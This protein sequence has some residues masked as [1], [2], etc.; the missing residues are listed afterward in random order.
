MG[1]MNPSIITRDELIRDYVRHMKAGY[2]TLFAGAGLS[3]E[4]GYPA[5]ADLLQDDARKLGVNL[6]NLNGYDYYDFANWYCQ[7]NSDRTTLV[8][9]IV[10]EI[11]K[12]RPLSINHRLIAR[13][14]LSKIW[15]TN[16]DK[17]LETALLQQSRKV[18]VISRD[19]DFPFSE[20]EDVKV[21]KMH[22][23]IHF[24]DDIVIT[25][26]DIDNYLR[27][28]E[29]MSNVF[30]SSLAQ[31]CFLF[32]GFGFKDLNFKAI[33]G[34][35]TSRYNNISRRHFAVLKRPDD[36]KE[37]ITFY[38]MISDLSKKGIKAYLIDS[39]DEIP[40]LLMDIEK[41]YIRDNIFV[42]GSFDKSFPSKSFEFPVF[43]HDNCRHTS[44]LSD[45][46]RSF[47]RGVKSR[48]SKEIYP[49]RDPFNSMP[50][51]LEQLGERMMNE[52][53]TLYT[54]FGLGVCDVVVEGASRK[55]V[56]EDTYQSIVNNIKIFPLP[57]KFNIESFHNQFYR[58]N[59]IGACGFML[60]ARGATH[61]SDFTSGSFEEYNIAKGLSNL[62]IGQQKHIIQQIKAWLK[63]GQHDHAGDT[64]KFREKLASL[65]R[66]HSTLVYY[67]YQE[68]IEIFYRL[69]YEQWKLVIRSLDACKFRADQQVHQHFPEWKEDW[70]KLKTQMETLVYDRAE[71][72]YGQFASKYLQTEHKFS[73]APASQVMKGL[74][75]FTAAIEKIAGRKQKHYLVTLLHTARKLV[76]GDY[77]YMKLHL[78]I[79]MLEKAEWNYLQARYSLAEVHADNVRELTN[80]Y[81]EK[82]NRFILF[83]YKYFD[84]RNNKTAGPGSL[85]DVNADLSELLDEG[86]QEGLQFHRHT[87][88][89]EN[90]TTEGFLKCHQ[91]ELQQYI[92]KMPETGENEHHK[93]YL[94]CKIQFYKYLYLLCNFQ[95]S[96]RRLE[97]NQQVVEIR[98]TDQL[99]KELLESLLSEKI[100]QAPER[101][102]TGQHIRKLTT[103]PMLLAPEDLR[104]YL[105]LHKKY[106]RH[107]LSHQ[108]V[109]RNMIGIKRSI[110]SMAPGDEATAIY[111]ID[112][113]MDGIK[114]I[115]DAKDLPY[116]SNP[117]RAATVIIPVAAV[118]GMARKVW[119]EEWNRFDYLC[120]N[121]NVEDTGKEKPG[122]TDRELLL[123]YYNQLY[124]IDF[125]ADMQ[126]EERQSRYKQ[127]MKAIFYIIGKFQKPPQRSW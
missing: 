122:K 38:Y 112:R 104:E 74:V 102:E 25:R 85:Q 49:Y 23:C 54:G 106:F 60:M 125:S 124:N 17:L 31:D 24:P 59:M 127:L 21:Y 35:I 40:I 75:A 9:K 100:M 16:Y 62:L 92:N 70:E 71:F 36:P 37:Q 90:G 1:A 5:W 95:R 19:K 3:A 103:D 105:E 96:L 46:T 26:D 94:V 79:Y 108:K 111:Q 114:K 32:L 45:D 42:S 53:L 44:V 51:F 77:K 6:D 58:E 73:D 116:K 113:C 89:Q 30:S 47:I 117:Y 27:Q 97:A 13:L 86:M 52:Q 10:Y 7:F 63:N 76:V 61:A 56:K 123:A 99:N 34:R 121:M 88:A 67:K 28:Y 84:N 14:P 109:L 107:F 68:I 2:A 41:A 15:T 4:S 29:I 126:E 11:S 12:P 119:K 87:C 72:F 39:Y 98:A 69:F 101:P 65:G 55:F 57:H 64:G 50:H 120:S 81:E 22:G 118:G 82:Y 78:F 115:R 83:L 18:K 48:I 80:R 66:Q 8:Q 33:L 93:K 110:H 43:K 20:L 91:E